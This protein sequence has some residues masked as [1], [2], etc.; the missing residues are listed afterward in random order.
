MPVPT[1]FRRTSSTLL[2]GACIILSSN[3]FALPDLVHRIAGI[4]CIWCIS[5]PPFRSGACGMRLSHLHTSYTLTPRVRNRFD[6]LTVQPSPNLHCRLI[7]YSS[8]P[9]RHP[10]WKR[11]WVTLT[12]DKKMCAFLSCCV[13]IEDNIEP[14]SPGQ[15]NQAPTVNLFR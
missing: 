5:S 14:H 1:S 8:Q 15:C 7:Q 12:S 13:L 4:S 9:Y 11:R 2:S 10:G 3:T 6:Y